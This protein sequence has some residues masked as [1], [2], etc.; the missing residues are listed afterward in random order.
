MDLAGFDMSALF[1][2]IS[3]FVHDH[4]LK[5]LGAV[6]ASFA[7][8]IWGA[9]WGWR[10]WK[11]RQDTGVI[12]YSQNSLV[13]ERHGV[14]NIVEKILVLDVYAENQLNQ[15][16]S[17]PVARRL[18]RRAAAKTTEDQPFLLFPKDDRWYVL[19]IVRL[20]IAE[21][22]R[23]GTAAKLAKS[24]KVEVVDCV[25]ALTY[26]RYPG[27]RQGKIRVMIVRHDVLVDPASFEGTV[28]VESP[29]HADRIRTLRKM[30]NDYLSGMGGEWQYCLTVRL[31]IQVS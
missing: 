9:W 12:H 31:N 29:S 3:E 11:T 23:S 13:V 25:F 6:L 17:H 7:S 18:I 26:E 2:H 24:A 28:K 1:G 16:I 15:D 27:M 14:S 4:W 19:N 20:S 30:Q 8:S 22:F 21:Q 10:K 5:A